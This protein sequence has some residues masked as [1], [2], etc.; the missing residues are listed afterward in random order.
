M[1]KLTKT[2]LQKLD[3]LHDSTAIENLK[4]QLIE[5]EKAILQ[6]KQQLF[7]SQI[8]LLEAEQKALNNKAQSH[9]SKQVQLK[10][11]LKEEIEKIS[12]HHK[13]K[14][15]LGYDPETGEIKEN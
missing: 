6:V 14:G 3:K 2:Q 13:I 10:K 12:K 7:K 15:P 8:A 5:K 9:K 11:E 4:E 1:K